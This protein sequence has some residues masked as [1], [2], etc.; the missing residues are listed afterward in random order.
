MRAGIVQ[1]IV[2]YWL[3]VSLNENSRF[4]SFY[5]HQKPS[6]RNHAFG[7]ETKLYFDLHFYGIFDANQ[8]KNKTELKG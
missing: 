8:I 7:T 6:N 2:S 4:T 5:Y 3:K 1:R